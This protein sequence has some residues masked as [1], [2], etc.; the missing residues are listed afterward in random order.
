MQCTRKK[1]ILYTSPIDTFWLNIPWLLIQFFTYSIFQ[2]TTLHFCSNT[3]QLTNGRKQMTTLAKKECTCSV[4]GNRSSFPIILSTN[5]FGSADLDFRPPAMER[6]T[7]KYRIQE[8]PT[9]EYVSYSIEMPPPKGVTLEWLQSEEYQSCSGIELNDPMVRA[10]YRDYLICKM[11]KRLRRT[12]FALRNTVWICDDFGLIE[13]AQMFRKETARLAHRYYRRTWNP[14][15]KILE[16][17]MLRRARQFEGV[18]HQK[19]IFSKKL[20]TVQSSI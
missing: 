5:C 19:R 13:T 4:C 17:D 14:G 6:D 2:A 11:R 15:I 8:C 20:E 18:L 3:Q 16:C 1:A 12:L 7:L 10:F 9:C